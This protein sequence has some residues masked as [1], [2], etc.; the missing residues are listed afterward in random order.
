M[1][2][3]V[4]ITIKVLVA[5]DTIMASM[6]T[7]IIAIVVALETIAAILVYFLPKFVRIKSKKAFKEIPVQIR[8]STSN[9]GQKKGKGGKRYITGITIPTETIENMTCK[10]VLTH[11]TQ[12]SYTQS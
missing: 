11:S 7:K 2:L 12:P 6:S 10:G 4:R 9:P 1:F 5:T 3:F 8:G